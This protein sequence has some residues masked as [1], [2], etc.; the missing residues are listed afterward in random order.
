MCTATSTTRTTSTATILR[1][2]AW[3]RMSIRTR[4]RRYSTAMRTFRTFTTGIRMVSVSGLGNEA[5]LYKK[6]LWRKFHGLE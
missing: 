6:C 1:G 5:G 3:S 2:T 4:M